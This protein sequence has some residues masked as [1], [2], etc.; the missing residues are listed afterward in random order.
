MIDLTEPLSGVKDTTWT[1][2][3]ADAAMREVADSLGARAARDSGAGEDW[4]CVLTDDS[5]IAMISTLVPFAVATE[6]E[7]VMA[8]RAA[9]V[10]EVISVPSYDEP[11]LRCDVKVLR[12][13]FRCDHGWEDVVDP[14]EFSAHDLF[15]ATV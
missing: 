11:I 13:V 9:G 1:T 6:Q 14:R 8:L 3:N 7:A 5:L 10:L 4:S 2:E 12:E 15:W